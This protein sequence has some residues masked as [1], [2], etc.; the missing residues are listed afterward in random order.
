MSGFSIT[1]TGGQELKDTLAKFGK[2]FEDEIQKATTEGAN[3]VKK[4]VQS[5]IASR[6][7][8]KSGNLARGVKVKAMPRSPSFPLV[9]ICAMD[10]KISPHAYIV[11]YGTVPRYR[12]SGGFTGQMPPAGY[13]R[14]AEEQSRGEVQSLLNERAAAAVEKLNSGA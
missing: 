1:M 6:V 9:S 14:A 12:K 7:G 13:F 4:N 11:E 3:I 10:G 2:K 5:N 8:K